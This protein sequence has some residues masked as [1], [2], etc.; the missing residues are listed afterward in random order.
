MHHTG[1]RFLGKSRE[2]GKLQRIIYNN[3]IVVDHRSN[4]LLFALIVVS[5]TKMYESIIERTNTRIVKTQVNP[6]NFMCKI[7]FCEI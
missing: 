7:S 2:C 3:F 6:E 4:S 1:D 5:V